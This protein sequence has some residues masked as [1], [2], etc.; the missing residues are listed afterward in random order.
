[1]DSVESKNT[2]Q[3]SKVGTL[4]SEMDSVESKNTTQ[5]TRLDLIESKGTTAG[6]F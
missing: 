1:M 3:D 6:W 2:T 4:E 5:D